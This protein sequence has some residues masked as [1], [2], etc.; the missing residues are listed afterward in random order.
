ME[1]DWI[2]SHYK[3]QAWESIEDKVKIVRIERARVHWIQK[4]ICDGEFNMP[5]EV[6][7]PSEK[8]HCQVNRVNQWRISID[9]LQRR[10]RTGLGNSEL[11]QCKTGESFMHAY[12]GPLQ[13][14]NKKESQTHLEIEAKGVLRTYYFRYK[15]KR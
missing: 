1:T 14:A 7:I 12:L 8:G 6:V 5:E 11:R 13:I 9:R 2:L 3:P 15:K 10:E 4:A